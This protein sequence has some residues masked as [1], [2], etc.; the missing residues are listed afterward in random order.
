MLFYLMSINKICLGN[1]CYLRSERSFAAPEKSDVFSYLLGIHI[2]V[3]SLKICNGRKALFQHWF[4]YHSIPQL[5][6]VTGVAV[7]I[8]LSSACDTLFAQVGK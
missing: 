3:V 4:V 2:S 7:A 6:N 8:G 5:M 1:N